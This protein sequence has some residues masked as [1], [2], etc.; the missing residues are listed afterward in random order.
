MDSKQF[1]DYKTE[2]AI[3]AQDMSRRMRKK[4]MEKILF[5]LHYND[6]K[7]KLSSGAPGEDP[8]EQEVLKISSKL[9]KG[10][11]NISVTGY[12]WFTF[13]INP[14]LF[15]HKEEYLH[16]LKKQVEKAM[17]KKCVGRAVWNYELTKDGVP[18]SHCLIQMDED[19]LIS[20]DKL[21]KGFQN[22]FKDVGF[23]KFIHTNEEWVQDKIEYLKGN[24]WDEDKLEMITED[25]RWRFENGIN[26]IYTKG[27]WGALL[28]GPPVSIL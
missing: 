7:E 18:H 2:C 11:R 8:L 16:R 21:F 20:K 27:D 28:D 6:F 23:V 4:A 9:V 26:Q 19:N 17:T 14:A 22:T 25:I 12:W 13:T 5:E 1:E 10:T 24:K 3:E 15:I